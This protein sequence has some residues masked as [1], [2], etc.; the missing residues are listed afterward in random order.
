MKNKDYVS[1][2]KNKRQ[3]RRASKARETRP[4]PVFKLSMILVAVF[5]FAYFLS[6]ID[7]ESSSDIVEREQKTTTK[8]TK[9]TLPPPP[10]DEEWQFIE[11][12]ENKQVKVSTEELEDKGPYI[13]RCTTVRS[14]ERAEALKAKIAFAGFE[15]Q[16]KEYKG[17]SGVWYRVDLGPYEK[18]RTAEKTRHELKRNNIH[19]CL[20]R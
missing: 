5:G 20:F 18:K 19:G 15:S 9:Q 6:Q 3:P 11:E 10:E 14:R 2:N 16:V 1:Q 8:K 17:T 13:V 12:L 7:G 4:F